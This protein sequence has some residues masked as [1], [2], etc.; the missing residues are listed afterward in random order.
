MFIYLLMDILDCFCVA[1]LCNIG[2]NIHIQVFCVNNLSTSLVVNICVVNSLGDV[3]SRISV[4]EWVW[5]FVHILSSTWCLLL[6]FVTAIFVEMRCFIMLFD[7]FWELLIPSTSRYLLPFCGPPFHK[8]LFKYLNFSTRCLLLLC[9]Y[10]CVF[11]IIL[12]LTFQ[13][14]SAMG[15]GVLA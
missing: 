12:L 3:Q 15:L 1:L 8:C 9:I 11:I 10:Y 6:F 4:C 5:L 2:M 14:L 13:G 7:I